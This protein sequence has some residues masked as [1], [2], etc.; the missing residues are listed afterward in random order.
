L[1]VAILRKIYKYVK[2]RKDMTGFGTEKT[3]NE[4]EMYKGTYIMIHLRG[5]GSI[6][7][8]KVAE[9]KNN[10][11]IFNPYEGKLYNRK[12]GKLVLQMIPKNLSIHIPDIQAIEETTRRDLLDYCYGYNKSNIKIK[13]TSFFA[14][15]IKKFS[16]LENQITNY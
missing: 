3:E 6:F 1:I 9:I 11:V 5:G 12:T 8:G 13:P 14:R 2:V 15:L 4:Y 7:A 10:D 16:K